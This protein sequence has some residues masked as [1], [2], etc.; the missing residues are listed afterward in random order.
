MRLKCSLT[1]EKCHTNLQSQTSHISY[2]VSSFLPL[3]LHPTA[4]SLAD[5]FPLLEVA[6]M[7]MMGNNPDPMCVFTYVQSLCHSLSKIENERRNKEKEEKEKD[8][9]VEAEKEKE[10]GAAGDA[11]THESDM[12]DSQE[13]TKGKNNAEEPGEEEDAAKSCELE[14]GEGELVKEQS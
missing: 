8:G 11:S 5:C 3:P 6:D 7:I 1:L 10:D 2:S 13:E 12:M 9:T 14:G 4:R